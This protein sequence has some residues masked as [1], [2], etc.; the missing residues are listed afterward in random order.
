MAVDIG[1]IRDRIAVTVA[2]TGLRC[3]GYPPTDLRAP[4]AYVELD[5]DQA[6][7]YGITSATEKS[8]L[9]LHVVVVAAA[10]ENGPG[11][12]ERLL[13]QYL[14]TSGPLSI[15]QTLQA[16]ATCGGLASGLIVQD[17]VTQYGPRTEYNG[18]NYVGARLSVHVHTTG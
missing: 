2:S 1:A 18:I 14:T 4:Y 12:G 7:K 15:R 6:I 13:D 9:Y 17:F 5:Q 3:T 10:L 11:Q 16:D 8:T